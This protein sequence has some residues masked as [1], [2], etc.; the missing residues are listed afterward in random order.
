MNFLKLFISSELFVKF[1]KGFVELVKA[2][3][4]IQISIAIAI[5]ILAS[6]F[7]ASLYSQAK[8]GKC[9]IDIFSEIKQNI[10]EVK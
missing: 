2:S 4:I 3:K 8:S 9:F 7:G 1:C 5:I 10:K 6:S